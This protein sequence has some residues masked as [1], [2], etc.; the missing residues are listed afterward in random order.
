MVNR[1]IKAAIGCLEQAEEYLWLV[2]ENGDALESLVALSIRD[3]VLQLIS[4]LADFQ[5][6]HEGRIKCRS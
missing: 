4:D 6:A 3:G 5:A 1:D 2:H